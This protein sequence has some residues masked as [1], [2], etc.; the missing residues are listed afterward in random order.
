M[1]MNIHPIKKAQTENT[2]SQFKIKRKSE[3]IEAGLDLAPPRIKE[4]WNQLKPVRSLVLPQIKERNGS[5]INDKKNLKIISEEE[6]IDG[7][8]RFML[9]TRLLWKEDEGISSGMQILSNTRYSSNGLKPEQPLKTIKRYRT[10]RE[11]RKPREPSLESHDHSF[12]GSK[13]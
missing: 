5:K 11:S 10:F 1:S 12:R 2:V 13:G 6:G 3:H 8:P 7:S 9:E 4:T